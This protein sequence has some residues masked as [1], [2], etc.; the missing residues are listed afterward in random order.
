M[1]PVNLPPRSSVLFSTHF[2]NLFR[3]DV[4][5]FEDVGV[6]SLDRFGE[7]AEGVAVEF[8]E[9]AVPREARVNDKSR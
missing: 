4:S 7:G 8:E 2:P 3:L 6:R 1:F 5:R 9:E